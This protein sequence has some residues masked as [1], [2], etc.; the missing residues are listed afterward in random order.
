MS[1]QA[2]FAKQHRRQETKARRR[3]NRKARATAATMALATAAMAVTGGTAAATGDGSSPDDGLIAFDSNREVLSTIDVFTIDPDANTP[4][5]TAES[6]SDNPAADRNAQW[7]PDG[8]QIAYVSRR[9][10]NGDLQ[11]QVYVQPVGDPGSA[12]PVTLTSAENNGGPAQGV[13]FRGGLAWSPD[14]TEIAFVKSSTQATGGNIWVVD[15]A[16]G[17]ERQITSHPATDANPTWSPGGGSIAFESNRDG[18]YDIYRVNASGT[19]AEEGLTNLTPGFAGDQW[20]PDYSRGGYLILYASQEDGQVP[21]DVYVKI[22]SSNTS[23]WQLTT[24]T[25]DEEVPR[26]SPVNTRFTY[27]SQRDGDTSYDI[28]TQNLVPDTSSNANVRNITQATNIQDRRPDWQFVEGSGNTP[29]RVENEENKEQSLADEAVAAS[30]SPLEALTGN[31]Q[32]QSGSYNDGSSDNA[33]GVSTD[34]ET[35]G[36]GGASSDDD[37]GDGGSHS[38]G[39]SSD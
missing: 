30:G 33:G 10:V 19:G 31:Q 9:L 28:F 25:T 36:G 26:W 39:G 13:K 32:P 5:T 14:G 29:C 4:P 12:I 35:D 1:K 20:E 11:P 7:S 16:T 18:D 8:S 27:A 22:A 38:D 6:E 15:V 37:G 34:C 3:R 2:R 23:S 17:A 21:H 24:S